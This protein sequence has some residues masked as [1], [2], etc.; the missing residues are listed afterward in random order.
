MNTIDKPI[1]VAA[2]PTAGGKTKGAEAIMQRCP[3]IER[4]CTST[5]RPPRPGERSGV[6][7]RFYDTPEAFRAKADRGEFL[8]WD[9]P[10]G[11]KHLYGTEWSAL[12]YIWNRGKIPLALV[13]LPGVAVYTEHFPSAC[14]IFILPP[15]I[16]QLESRMRSDPS[17][18][19]MTDDEI[20]RRLAQAKTEIDSWRRLCQYCVVNGNGE[21]DLMVESFIAIV[22]KHYPLSF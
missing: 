12:K 7:Y 16:D 15:S 19:N 2:A 5:S 11:G 3:Y 21:L 4:V 8:E 6:H 13:T 1:I 9:Q 18:K 10:F 17:R 22:R 20:K 14:T